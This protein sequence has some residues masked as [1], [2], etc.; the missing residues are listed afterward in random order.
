MD[1][2][3]L[4]M[5]HQYNNYRD[6]GETARVALLLRHK[7]RMWR[8]GMKNSKTAKNVA[9][10]TTYAIEEKEPGRIESLSQEDVEA[11]ETVD[12]N[13]ITK[14]NDNSTEVVD[15][16]KYSSEAPSASTAN[17]AVILGQ[18]VAYFTDRADADDMDVLSFSLHHLFCR[19][20]YLYCK[21]LPA[22][23]NCTEQ[24][25]TNDSRYRQHIWSGLQRI[26]RTLDRM[27]PLCHLLSDA[28]EC[29]LDAFDNSSANEMTDAEEGTLS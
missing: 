21:A 16:R 3:S 22:L 23:Q 10:S 17:L 15:E 1:H 12:P 8:M 18:L 6:V 26:N 20:D 14:D 11:I 2:L 13:L 24:N 25:L 9:K 4:A 28:T 27:E 5:S 19:I 29:I 7:L